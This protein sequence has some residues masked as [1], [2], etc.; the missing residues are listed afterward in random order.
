MFYISTT[1][2]ALWQGGSNTGCDVIGVV[3]LLHK[4]IPQLPTPFTHWAQTRVQRGV[5]AINTP[6]PAPPSGGAAVTE[7]CSG[8]RR[9]VF[10]YLK[11]LRVYFWRRTSWRALKV[12]WRG[13]A[14]QDHGWCSGRWSLNAPC[15]IVLVSLS[16]CRGL[17][18]VV[19]EYSTVDC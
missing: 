9:D 6:T 14:L 19:V 18:V 2:Q 4:N 16:L 15:C 7:P 11:I 13:G 3:S 12:F 5:L 17:P 1:L 8:H 10:Y